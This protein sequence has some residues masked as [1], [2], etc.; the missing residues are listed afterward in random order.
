MRLD[1]RMDIQSEKS[2]WSILHSE[3]KT[4]VLIV[5]KRNSKGRKTNTQIQ[6][7]ALIFSLKHK[8]QA[9]TI[10]N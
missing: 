4:L 10:E 6:A 7:K 8:K 2:A 5:L 3:L 1:G 9:T